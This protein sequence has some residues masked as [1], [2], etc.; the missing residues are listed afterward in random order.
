M[1]RKILAVDDEPDIVRL[2]TAALTA[3][4]YEVISAAD[5]EEALD[6]AVL[7]KPDLI[8]LDIMMPKMDGREV[9][10]RLAAKPATAK[11][12]IVFLSAIG[13]LDSQ[14]DTLE[15]LR[16]VE[17]LTKPFDVRELAEYVDAMLDPSKRAE[18]SR[19]RARQ[20]GKL[21]TM[22]DIMHRRRQGS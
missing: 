16:G 15:E 4:G 11:I 19:Q 13:D 2:V 6:K 7:E 17:Y 8:V 5:G 10:R 1:A 9:A 12:P 20:V 18:L 3:R 22:V 21:R 14:L